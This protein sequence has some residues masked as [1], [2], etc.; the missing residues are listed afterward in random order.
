MIARAAIG[1]DLGFCR[2]RRF[3]VE[4]VEVKQGGDRKMNR[5]TEELT[6]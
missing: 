5:V 1:G 3:I 2:V 6:A 4:H